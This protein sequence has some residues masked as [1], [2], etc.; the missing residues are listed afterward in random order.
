MDEKNDNTTETESKNNATDSTTATSSADTTYSDWAPSYP[1]YTSTTTGSGYTNIGYGGNAS[2]TTYTPYYSNASTG[3]AIGNTQLGG[4]AA[5][6]GIYSSYNQNTQQ[7]SNIKID[8]STGT[9][10]AKNFVLDGTNLNDLLAT[11]CERLAIIE[12]VD[13]ETIEKYSSLQEAYKKYKF[14]ENLLIDKNKPE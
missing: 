12:S 13:P 14:L 7:W 1:T 6:G 9:V 10:G 5:G 8:Y 2:Y 4:A 3:A 11:I